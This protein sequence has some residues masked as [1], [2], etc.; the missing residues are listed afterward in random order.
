MNAGS[1][2]DGGPG[3]KR[4]A[5]RLDELQRQ[6]AAHIRDPDAHPAPEG[7]ED[8][9]MAVYRE[10]FFNNIRSMLASNF[11]VL[12]ALHEPDAWTALVRDFYAGYRCQTPLFT[13]IAREFLRY[14]Q[15]RRDTR[16][17]D[18]PFMA[19]LA[20]YEWIEL[21][22]ELDERELDAVP[23][24]PDGDPVDSVPVLSPLAWPLTYRFPVHRIRPDFRPDRPP[25]EATHLLVWRNR[26]DEV[27]FMS[28]NAVARLLLGGLQDRPQAT[29]RELLERLAA[30]IGHPD[31]ERVVTHGAELLADFMARDILLG[32]R[33]PGK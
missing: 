24:D 21:A 33:I 7:I 13:E 29:G 31:P 19:E 9:R 28:L 32:T 8:R 14:L 3:R 27:C 15:E 5:S 30:D 10:L 26:R 16:P 11:P 12:H 17:G 20:H 18:P 1:G 2:P 6:F 22:L 23:A 4:P 25:E